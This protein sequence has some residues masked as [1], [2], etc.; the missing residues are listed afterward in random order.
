MKLI[1]SLLIFVMAC[2]LGCGLVAATDSA[3][4]PHDSVVELKQGS[5]GLWSIRF[6]RMETWRPHFSLWMFPRK[7]RMESWLYVKVREGF[8]EATGVWQSALPNEGRWLLGSGSTRY[9]GGITLSR[10]TV[11]V[12]IYWSEKDDVW[13]PFNYNGHYTIGTGLPA[14]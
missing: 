2:A 13:Q 10:D 14:K 7:A 3:M 5:D 12:A 1:R 11:D 8:T 4:A 6:T 9:K